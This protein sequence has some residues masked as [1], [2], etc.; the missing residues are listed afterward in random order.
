MNCWI[1]KYPKLA[2]TYKD[3]DGKCPRHT[4]F[5]PSERINS[6]NLKE[7]NKL[8]YD[9][10]GEIEL[11]LHHKNDTSQSLE[12]KFNMAKEEYA[13][14]GIL[15]T[16]EEKPKK[17]F[18][19]VHGNWG[20]DNSLGKEF[21]GVNNEL[22]IL[23][24]MN[25]YAD[26]TFPSPTE[27]QPRRINCIY[28]TKDDPLLPKS[29]NDGVDVEVDKKPNGDLMLIQGPLGINW[30]NW[31]NIFYPSIEM[32]NINKGNLPV[33]NRV[34]FW[35]DTGIHVKNRPE[36][37][38][39]KVHCHGAITEDLATLLGEPVDKMFTYLEEKYN[40]GKNY[41]LHYVTAREAYNIIKAAEAGKLGNTGDFRDYIIKPYANTLINTD[42][43]YE[44]LTFSKNNLKINVL[45][46]NRDIKFEFKGL[47]LK[48]VSGKLS[49]IIFSN[50]PEE[51]KL[52]LNLRGDGKVEFEICLKEKPP[53]VVNANID[54]INKTDNIHTVK[55]IADLADK[56]ESEIYITGE[57]A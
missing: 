35:V 1:E 51:N 41:L 56:G 21:C 16:A 39:I 28:Y 23:N 36:W 4:W 37:I 33:K 26:F 43:L 19:F 55:F 48:K 13:K 29:Y 9:G 12:E 17:T 40:D 49:S 54:S 10:Y 27:A 31:K 53:K 50:I 7:L 22:Q 34:D 30:R 47:A 15:I 11:Q 20:L 18:A 3:S 24:K 2:G 45:E 5:Y 6:S 44:L 38:F 14:L 42:A 25:C 57:P 32:A 46:N 52:G 8:C